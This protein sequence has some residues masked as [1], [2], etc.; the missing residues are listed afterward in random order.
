MPSTI[1]AMNRS[2]K[3]PSST[4]SGM[5]Y[6]VSEIAARNRPFSAQSS[7]ST[8]VMARRRLIIR[9][10]PISTSA[11][12]TPKVLL[13]RLPVSAKGRATR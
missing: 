3:T 13:P 7:A 2:K 6:V 10:K 4:T 11:M 12:A 8:W 9:K 5:P 1:I